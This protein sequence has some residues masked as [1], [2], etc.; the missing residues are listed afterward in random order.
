M[1]IS[2]V[3]IREICAACWI[4]EGALRQIMGRMQG[5]MPALEVEWVVYETPGQ[6]MEH[7]GLEE[8]KFPSIFYHGEQMTAGEIPTV[9]ELR[10]WMEA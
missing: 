7:P 2:V 6:A 9:E 5:R 8:P 10:Q 4:V 1:K 3:T